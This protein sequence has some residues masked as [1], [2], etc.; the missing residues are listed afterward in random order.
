ME[1]VDDVILLIL[2][3]CS[4]LTIININQ[5]CKHWRQIFNQRD[6]IVKLKRKFSTVG[7]FTNISDLMI[8]YFINNTHDHVKYILQIRTDY[9]N[10]IDNVGDYLRSYPTSYQLNYIKLFIVE[11]CK[12]NRISIINNLL[13]KYFINHTENEIIMYKFINELFSITSSKSD[14][15]SASIIK[16]LNK[17]YPNNRLSFPSEYTKLSFII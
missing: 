16:L 6:V 3:K 11:A 10:V 13:E 8:K 7:K 14:L 15:A 9:D 1:L 5:V 12:Y 17:Y 4:P 2:Y